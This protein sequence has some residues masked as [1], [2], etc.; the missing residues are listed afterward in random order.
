MSF[1]NASCGLCNIY[2]TFYWYKYH[3]LEKVCSLT[4]RDK[5]TVPTRTYNWLFP[6]YL[7]NTV[8]YSCFVSELNYKCTEYCSYYVWQDLYLIW[9]ASIIFILI[10]STDYVQLMRSQEIL[11]PLSLVWYKFYYF[12]CHEKW[13][14][15]FIS[16]ALFQLGNVHK[17]FTNDSS[18][19]LSTTT[20]FVANP[21]V[22]SLRYNLNCTLK[23]VLASR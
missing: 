6:L 11:T 8:K 3:I 12:D 23:H 22:C 21:T 13:Y 19:L 18:W 4:T 10:F 9:V 5:L 20:N 1:W 15:T 2:N 17:A 14:S 16:G 7:K